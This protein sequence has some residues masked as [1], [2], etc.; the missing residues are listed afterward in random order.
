[1]SG[2]CKHFLSIHPVPDTGFH[3]RIKNKVSTASYQ[4]SLLSS[5]SANRMS[6]CLGYP[7]HSTEQTLFLLES[8]SV[9]W[10]CW[11]NKSRGFI[12]ESWQ[13]SFELTVFVSERE[14]W[15]VCLSLP[16]RFNNAPGWVRTIH[17]VLQVRCYTCTV[18]FLA[19]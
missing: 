17:I 12:L 18:I 4:W 7:K 2:S 14:K 13:F 11:E 15:S 3:P 6:L 9:L 8:L 1:M 5:Q 10:P 16:H 19:F